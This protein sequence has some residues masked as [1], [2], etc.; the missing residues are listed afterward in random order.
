MYTFY[1]YP[2]ACSKA[3]Y[4]L[5]EDMG[6][7]YQ[8]KYVDI[9]KGEQFS[10]EY[11]KMNPRSQVPM[12]QDGNNYYY[13]GA[14][15]MMYL[16]EKYPNS[17]MMPKDYPMRFKAYEGMMYMNSYVHQMYAQ[18]FKAKK[19]MDAAMFAKMQPYFY[20]QFTKYYDDME[21]YY[22]QYKFYAGDMMTMADVMFTIFAGWNEYCGF[23]YK[24]GPNCQRVMTAVNAYPAYAKV[25]EKETQAY[26]QYAAA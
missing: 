8:A 24:F 12:L 10:P 18:Y 5:L 26:K 2:G 6:V 13:E 14:A 4:M 25:T 17:K 9:Q 15:I 16:F 19:N 21:K 1:Y 7:P 23:N 11:M 20:E 22:G 3:C